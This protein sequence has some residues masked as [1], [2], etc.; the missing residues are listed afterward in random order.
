MVAAFLDKQ[1]QE[2]NLATKRVQDL[3]LAI[4]AYKNSRSPGQVLAIRLFQLAVQPSLPTARDAVEASGIA[5][6]SSKQQGRSIRVVEPVATSASIYP[7]NLKGFPRTFPPP[8]QAQGFKETT[9]ASA[10]ETLGL[11]ARIM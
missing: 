4:K 10:W 11:L 6:A 5:D 1:S 2:L 8:E 3:D 7:D 9:T